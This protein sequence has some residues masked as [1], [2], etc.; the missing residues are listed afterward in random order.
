MK[1]HLKLIICYELLL[2]I[3]YAEDINGGWWMVVVVVAYYYDS[4]FFVISKNHDEENDHFI[5]TAAL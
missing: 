2:E 4:I 1:E 5:R 3:T